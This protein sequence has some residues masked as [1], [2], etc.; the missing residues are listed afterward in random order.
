MFCDDVTTDRVAEFQES[1]KCAN[2]LGGNV[3]FNRGNVDLKRDG[4][5]DETG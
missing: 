3:P 5:S 1:T 2:Y 4:E